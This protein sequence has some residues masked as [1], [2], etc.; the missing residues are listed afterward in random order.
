LAARKGEGIIEERKERT[1]QRKTRTTVTPGFLKLM[2]DLGDSRKKRHKDWRGH[3]CQGKTATPAGLPAKHLKR[4]ER[5]KNCQRD[6]RLALA[7]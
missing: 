1:F 7:S 5:R 3:S 4:S 2:S 6:L